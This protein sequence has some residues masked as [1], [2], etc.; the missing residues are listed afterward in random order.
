MRPAM[1]STPERSSRSFGDHRL[2]ILFALLL[3]G[4]MVL[5]RVLGTSAWDLGDGALHYLQV[6]FAHTNIHL[7]FDRWAKPLYVLLGAP[8]AQIGPIGMVLFNALV[9]WLTAW[10]ILSLLGPVSR[11]IAWMVPVLLFTSIQYFRVVVSG[12][13]EP[14]F[15]L[16]TIACLLLLWRE[17]Y[18]AAMI[19]LSLAPWSRPEY[20]V[21]APFAV[22]WVLYNRKWKALPWVLS[23]T[24]VYFLLGWSLL[25]E[26][27]WHFVRDPYEGGADF[28]EGPLWHFVV[29]APE[30][31]G[32]ALLLLACTALPVLLVLLLR[33]D[34]Q[35]R[36]HAFIL[37]L[38]VAPVVCIWAAHSYAYW[39][40]GHASGGL[41]RVLSTAAPLTVL[42]VAHAFASV[43]QRWGSR[44]A[45][46]V[47]MAAAM[48]ITVWAV[49]D[50]QKT[51]QLPAAA[52][53][54]QQLV[55]RAA[56]AAMRHAEPG[57]KIYSSHPYFALVAGLDIGDTTRN[58][59]TWEADPARLLPGDLVQW[60]HLYGPDS[61]RHL[62]QQLLQHEDFAVLSMDLESE[63][64]WQTPFGV[65]LFQRTSGRQ[66]W[67]VDT[68]IDVQRGVGNSA[69]LLKD[70]AVQDSAAGI[71]VDGVEY[72]MVIAPL[73]ACRSGEILTEWVVSVDLERLH[74][75]ADASILWVFENL[76]E[77]N[78]LVTLEGRSGEGRSEVRFHQG[79]R[80]GSKVMRVFLWNI[81]RHAVVLNDLRVVRRCLMPVDNSAKGSL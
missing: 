70:G 74:G 62:Y 81:D 10:G 61:T 15:G 38:A 16:L 59:R 8:F 50:L 55:E 17:R 20:M 79:A 44:W 40:G 75:S 68:I 49:V 69:L 31:L 24:V 11:I 14:L 57:R 54:Q 63:G 25:K 36:K 27:I 37:L 77:G 52:S 35:R 12:L 29:Q 4:I 51:L 13:T 47:H 72:P 78:P 6:R 66:Q 58:G 39:I 7:F 67:V 5:L 60:D 22:A 9:A 3:A 23:G 42:F 43:Y 2:P 76:E 73:H 80:L 56:T 71:L 18:I 48:V 19:V 30:V 45:D 34:D 46:K 33:D 1:H 26:R 65:W 41:L 64:P 21:F 53:L 28:G 32:W